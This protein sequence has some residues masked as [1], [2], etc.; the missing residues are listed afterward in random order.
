MQSIGFLILTQLHKQKKWLHSCVCFLGFLY[1]S[2]YQCTAA[3]FETIPIVTNFTK[4]DYRAANQNWNIAQ[5]SKGR[6]YFAN[7]DGL[8]RYDGSGWQV[9]KLPN[10]M[11]VRSIAIDNNDRIYTG[12]YQEFGYWESGLDG[13]LKYQSVSKLLKH[14]SFNNDEIWRIVFYEDKVY[15]Q[16]FNSFFVLDKNGITPHKTPSIYFFSKLLSSVY[17]HGV[18]NLLFSLQNDKLQA[19]PNSEIFKNE[20]IRAIIQYGPDKLILGTSLHGLFIY[21]KKDNKFTHWKTEADQA[22][23]DGQINCGVLTKDSILCFGT[24]SNGIIGVDKEGHEVWHFT[25]SNYL[26]NNTILYLYNDFQNNIWAALDK[27]I[28]LIRRSSP[29][30]LL[31]ARADNLE[32][33]Y[34]AIKFKN[35]LYVGTNQGLYKLESGSLQNYFSLIPK[36]Q[37]QVWQLTEIDNQLLC[38]HNEGTFDI[39]GNTAT[40]I[41]GINGGEAIRKT[42]INN[43]EYLIQGTYTNLCI[44]EKGP[45]KKWRFRNIVKG[46]LNP[47]RFLEIDHLGNIWVSHFQKGIFRIRLNDDLTKVTEIKPYGEK[48]GLPGNYKVNVFKV[49]GRILFCTGNKIYTYDD[50]QNKVVEYSWL[51]QKIGEFSE[52]HLIIPIE[53]QIYWFVKRGKFALIRIN[54][55][56]AEILNTVPFSALNNNFID[57]NEY[58]TKLSN[59]QYVFCLDDGLALYNQ[60]FKDKSSFKPKL[61][62][63]KIE[64]ISDKNNWLLPVESSPK[65]YIAIPHSYRKIVFSFAYPNFSTNNIQYYCTLNGNKEESTDSLTTTVKTYS[66]LS[67]GRYQLQIIAKD[68][69]GK[70]YESECYYFEVKPPF[71]ASTFAWIIYVSMIV[72]IAYYTRKRIERHI[73]KQEQKIL[74]EQ[75]KIQKERIE[76]REQ[77]IIRLKNEKLEAELLHKSNELASST[78]S[79]IRKNDMLNQLKEE[80]KQQKLK[81]GTQYPNKYYDKIIQLIDN[82][83]S[84]DDDWQI[85]QQNFDMIHQDFFRNIRKKYPD[86]TLYDLKLCAYLRLNLST[87]EIASLLNISV[88]GVEAARY[89]LRKKLHLSVD[90]NLNEFFIEVR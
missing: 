89:R 17:V 1:L 11:G 15:F 59:T 9:F 64:A 41:S 85:F 78:M 21:N 58:I 61:L 18:N 71:Y 6:L 69:D 35:N 62:F 8:L 50:L 75:T 20:C 56:Q 28:T 36:T 23:I 37:G 3:E 39:E 67:P 57:E 76:R 40:R 34:T 22:L 84:S 5:D 48:E 88:R 25:K 74:E 70:I 27:G 44:Y 10:Q 45:D 54:N 65:S 72:G 90:E 49:E 52:S 68:K 19:V 32:A 87:K 63:Q 46:F 29:F 83:I 12:S 14:Y 2:Y 31:K 13:T 80:I 77:K 73:Q 4:N 30:S 66:Y 53:N 24:I 38:G 7:N 47:I 42:I 51:N 43:K 33:V 81:L 55:N 79:I 16:S 26:K 82:N 60:N 86:L